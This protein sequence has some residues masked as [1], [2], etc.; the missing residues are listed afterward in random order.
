MLKGVIKIAIEK[1]NE[2]PDAAT[3]MLNVHNTTRAVQ[4]AMLLLF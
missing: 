4:R 1:Y 2:M 3:L